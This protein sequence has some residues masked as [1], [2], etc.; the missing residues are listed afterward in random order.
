MTLRDV[1]RFAASAL[2]GYL[3][4]CA[5]RLSPAA[6]I[7][8]FEYVALVLAIFWGITLFGEWPDAIAWVGTALVLGGGLFVLW[9]ESAVDRQVV[10]RRP[11]PRNR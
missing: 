1:L 4:S 5:Y 11:M 9:R 7:A 8:P 6:V 2:G 10:S 3:I